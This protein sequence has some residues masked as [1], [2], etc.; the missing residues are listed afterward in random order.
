MKVRFLVIAGVMV[1]ELV[2]PGVSVATHGQDYVRAR[3]GQ[4][5]GFGAETPSGWTIEARSG[6]NGEHPRGMMRYA[7]PATTRSFLVTCLSVDGVE[8]IVGGAGD[9]GGVIAWVRS[10]SGIEP[11]RVVIQELASPPAD[12][13]TPP[14]G[15]GSPASVVV[16]DS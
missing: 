6:P 3:D 12:C 8:A 2:S 16:H 9:T 13:S 7:G 15:D 5:P 1:A 4:E 10:Q 11:G 14:E